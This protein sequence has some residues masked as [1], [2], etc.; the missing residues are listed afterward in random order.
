MRQ[1]C[2]LSLIP[3][4]RKTNTQLC[5][6]SGKLLMHYTFALFKLW[7]G[8]RA[9]CLLVVRRKQGGGEKC[10]EW[11]ENVIV[12]FVNIRITL[13]IHTRFLHSYICSAC[14]EVNIS[15]VSSVQYHVFVFESIHFPHMNHKKLVILTASNFI[16]GLLFFDCFKLKSAMN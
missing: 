5:E 3:T 16:F 7:L 9:V 14:C 10:E 11:E 4:G 6:V 8:A 2:G 1:G 13:A 12:I 15:V